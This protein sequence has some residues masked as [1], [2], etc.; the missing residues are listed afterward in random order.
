MVVG[1]QPYELAWMDRYAQRITICI[2]LFPWSIPI[3]SSSMPSSF[4]MKNW[5][6]ACFRFF[7]GGGGSY[8]SVR[9]AVLMITHL[10]L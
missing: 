6:W 3:P 5:E 1:D 9:V 2:A 4:N 10:C 8:C 7:F